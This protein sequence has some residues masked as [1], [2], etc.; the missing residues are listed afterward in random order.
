M[1][2]FRRLAFVLAL[3]LPAAHV[4]LAQDSSSSTPAP[5][6]L[7]QA[8]SESQNPPQA[9]QPAA[10]ETQGELSVQARIRARRAQRR[11]QAIHDTYSQLYEAFVGG[12]FM[13]FRPGSNLQ[14]ANM[15]SWDAALTRYY[16]ERFGVTVDGRGY[17]GTAYVGLN[18]PDITRPSIS[19][20]A[21]MGGP[22][23][24]FLLH[25]KYSLAVRGMG[26]V[27]MGNFSGDTGG[28]PPASLGLYPNATTY[29][30]NGGIIGEANV[31]PNLAIRLAGDFFGTG[32]GSQM[33]DSFGFTYG[34]VY[35]FGKR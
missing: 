23:Y 32:F 4:L 21:V 6:E 7:A 35:R 11:A 26:G 28:F 8:Q 3:S 15:F 10:Q 25:P 33:Q 30:V 22:T 13:R 17:Y 12:G 5:V 24:R 34:I 2:S 27:D 31:S 14:R 9:Q 18:Q 29:A 1:Y 16:S 20:Y 19:Q